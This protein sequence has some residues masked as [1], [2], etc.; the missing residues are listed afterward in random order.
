MKE[1]ADV[2]LV[3][4]G[5]ANGVTAKVLAQAGL[6][7]VAFEAG[8]RVDATMM[9]PDEIRNDV[10]SWLSQ[11]KA[12]H[13]TPTF[14]PNDQTE[15]R[16]VPWAVLMVNAVGGTTA[17]Y[18][19]VSP[20]LY[21]WNFE[22]RTQTIARYGPNAIPAGS[23][24]ED[25]P[26][27]YDDIEPYYSLVERE[28]G[29]CGESG[30]LGGVIQP[31]GNRFEG[32]RSVD[33]PMPPLRRSGWTNLMADAARSLGWHPYSAPATI[34]SVPYNNQPACTYCGFCTYNGCYR[35]AKGATYTNLIPAAE[36]TG[37][38]RILTDARVASINTDREG[39]ASGVTYRI[40]NRQST[41][42][43]RAV[44]LGCFTYENTRLLLL[45]R[46]PAFP[47]G[48]SNNHNQVGKHFMVH[49]LP[50]VTGLFPGRRLKLY[51]GLWP[52]AAN[53]DD[54]NC[55][56]FDHTD[57]GFLGGGMLQTSQEL[58][59]IAASQSLPPHIPRWG[60]EWKAWIHKNAQSIGAA[61]AQLEGL[62]YETNYLDLDPSTTDLAG[63]PVVRITYEL[64]PAERRG[65]DFLQT[66]L[67]EWLRAAG[68]SETWPTVVGASAPPLGQALETSRDDGITIEGRH[69]Y[70]GTRMGDD[71]A[72][73]VVNR[74]SFCHEVPNLAVVGPSTFPTTGGHN[75][76]LTVQA[77]AWRTAE[78]LVRNWSEIAQ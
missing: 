71:P 23:T 34:N 2:I 63:L 9:R 55:D 74:F 28:I 7:V 37:N 1:H 13:E 38:L 51:A 42:T 58:K 12:V 64:H 31:R 67:A 26:L 27:S 25:W 20:R 21:P 57:L 3:G 41:M 48:L 59:P 54:W 77:L 40:G 76:T 10:R 47:N 70:G 43:A 68:A 49:P 36:R 60:S 65:Y 56:N 53:V 18:A 5:A 22:T 24:V 30:N 15:D 17:H 61:H 46:S 6:D 33:Y 75:P 73:S 62:S 29:I 19:A 52:Q 44:I 35:D 72:A 4:L 11:A 14:R 66:K 8:A 16:P 39:R 45:S 69:A 32:P 50:Q 78:H